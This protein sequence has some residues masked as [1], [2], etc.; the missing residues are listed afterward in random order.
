MVLR[1]AALKYD[2]MIIMESH[3]SATQAARGLSDVLNRVLYRGEVFIVERGGEPICRMEPV[4]PPR[5]TARSLMDLLRA[6]PKPDPEF[7]DEVERITRAQ[8][9]AREVEW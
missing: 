6:G 9:P 5:C 8:P 3:I 7:W 2:N 1:L 4:G